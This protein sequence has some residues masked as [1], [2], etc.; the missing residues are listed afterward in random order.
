M[1]KEFIVFFPVDNGDTVLISAGNKTIL[2]DVHYR[3]ACEEK[4]SDAYDFRPDL[5][6]AC[7]VGREKRLSLFVS[8]HPDKDHCRGFGVLFHT[9]KPD[10]Y[11]SNSDKILVEEIWCSSYGADPH[12]TT[13]DSEALVKEIKRRKRLIG[14]AEGAKD[15]NRLRI[16]D[17]NT[18][19]SS[20]SFGEKLQWELLAPTKKE[21]TIETSDDPEKPNSSNDSSLVIRWTYTDGSAKDMILLGGD[22][23]VDVW[24]RIWLQYP[25]EKLEWS[26]LLAP[27]HCSRCT[28]ARKNEEDGEYVYS[29]N[30]LSALGQV[31][32]D[33]FIVS[34]S[35][36]V[37][38]DDDNPP[39]WD[40]K[41][42]YLA[43]LK[44]ACEKDY[45]ERFLNPESHKKGDAAPVE[46]ELSHKG[47]TL[48]SASAFGFSIMQSSGAA[49]TPSIYG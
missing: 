28:M 23:G 40:A 30:A 1:A 31:D 20:G 48:K 26:V 34:S 7:K 13:E 3:K 14:T 19:P 8:T 35:K 9:G 5:K 49:A 21:A 16:L 22:A 36:P 11:H 6:A 15:G 18:S 2:T 47:I 17:L 27:H 41:Q 39:S 33:G 38:R 45:Q 32:G 46:F 42:K 43:I 37:K 29:S 44:S 24:E 25:A 10:D 12:Y 4:D